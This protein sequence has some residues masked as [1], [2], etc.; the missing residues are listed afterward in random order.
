MMSLIRTAAQ[1]ILDAIEFLT[2]LARA[3]TPEDVPPLFS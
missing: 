1:Q 2:R 3:P